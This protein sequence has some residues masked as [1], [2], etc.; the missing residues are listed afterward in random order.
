MNDY[1][2]I[3]SYLLEHLDESIAELVT[4]VAQP[5][6]GAQKLGMQECAALVGT[7]LEKRGFKVEILPTAGAPVVLAERKGKSDKTLLFCSTTI[8]MCS[9]PNRWTCGKPHRLSLRNGMA[10][11]M[12]AGSVMIKAT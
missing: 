12:G 5:S 3:D 8:M 10:N 6:V 11:Y 4:L 2:N 1:T 9:Q 7:M